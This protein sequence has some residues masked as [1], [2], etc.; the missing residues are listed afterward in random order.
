MSSMCG[1]F[2]LHQ[3]VAIVEQRNSDQH[4]VHVLLVQ[5]CMWWAE[6]ALKLYQLSLANI[7]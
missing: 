3:F 6:Q 5:Y 4:D 2:V 7:S 1:Q